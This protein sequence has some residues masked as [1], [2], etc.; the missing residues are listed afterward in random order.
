[1]LVVPSMVIT[2]TVSRHLA[3]RLF[4]WSRPGGAM[5]PCCGWATA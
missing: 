3:L 4:A 2:V 5:P 1:V